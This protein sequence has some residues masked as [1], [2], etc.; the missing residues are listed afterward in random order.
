M[1]PSPPRRPQLAFD[2]HV[3]AG[4]DFGPRYDGLTH[5][6]D[7]GNRKLL[8]LPLELM[9]KTNGPESLCCTATRAMVVASV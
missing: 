1:A 8:R 6:F 7:D 3:V 2:H 4:L 9:A 5:S